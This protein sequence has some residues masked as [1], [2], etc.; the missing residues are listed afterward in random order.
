MLAGV[1]V[2]VVCACFAVTIVLTFIRAR[3]GPATNA[4]MN[5]LRQFDGA[6]QQWALENHK[7]TNDI[8]S[9]QDMRPYLGRGTNGEL[10]TCPQGG[11][12]IL[13]RIGEPPRCSIDG[14]LS[15]LMTRGK[16]VT[17]RKVARPN[18][19]AAHAAVKTLPSDLCPS[20]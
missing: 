5:N 2:A 16:T 12:Y 10:P 3:S 1:A 11:V 6:K 13:G 7:T 9:W 8:P 17:G 20:V 14:R 19:A 18:V 15:G 4:C